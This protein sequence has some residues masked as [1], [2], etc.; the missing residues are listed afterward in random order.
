MITWPFH[1]IDTQKITE[2]YSKI[3]LSSRDCEAVRVEVRV[4]KIVKSCGALGTDLI[5]S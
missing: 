4:H 5:F 2:E 3:L 1:D